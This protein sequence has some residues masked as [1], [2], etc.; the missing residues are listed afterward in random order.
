M[1]EGS[2]PVEPTLDTGLGLLRD[3]PPCYSMQE[4]L[5]KPAYDVKVSE[6]RAQINACIEYRLKN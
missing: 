4:V 5:M 3:P 6:S 1:H 2:F